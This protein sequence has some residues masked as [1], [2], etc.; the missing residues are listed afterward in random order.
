LCERLVRRASK[1]PS[2]AQA[3][4]ILVPTRRRRHAA[5][6]QALPH[7]EV[8]EADVHDDAQ[9]LRLVGQ[10]H[11]VINLVAQLH[12]SAAELAR[13][14]VALPT[15]LAQACLQAGVRRI[16]HVSALGVEQ[17]TSR[18]LRSK[19]EGEA[20]LL[21]HHARGALQVSVLR[22]SVIFGANDKFTNLFAAMQAVAPVL[23]LACAQARFQPVWV[24]DVAA[25]IVQRLDSA[26]A[27]SAL[28]K[29]SQ[30][31]PVVECA[32][33]DILSLA[34]IVQ[35]CGRVAGHARAVLPLPAPLGRIQA[36]LLEALPGEPL[37]S[38]DNLDSMQH[39]NVAS[40]QY[41]GLADLG[42][43]PASMAQVLPTYL[44]SN[45]GPGRL[46]AWRALAGRP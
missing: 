13:P 10:S 28:A 15:R 46:D 8:I 27:R 31:P 36:M 1:L 9:L 18:Y 17:P 6:V 32:G 26:D 22:P 20:A 16:V 41:P 34:S 40:R 35:L 42:I 30:A 4:R 29:A 3:P 19:A 14:N 33:P 25:A 21:A 24:D 43:E 11:A 44:Q 7:V 37:M 39:A 38:R 5:A 12:G 45:A 23:P 2:R